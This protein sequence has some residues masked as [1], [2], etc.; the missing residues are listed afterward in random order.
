MYYVKM[1]KIK[2]CINTIYLAITLKS[3]LIYT[4]WIISRLQT[5]NTNEK[6]IV[7]N[8]RHVNIFRPT[9]R[10][11]IENYSEM[12]RALSAGFIEDR[13]VSSCSYNGRRGV[14]IAA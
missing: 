5:M 3:T 14:R 7:I 9:F 2:K 12:L 1:Y 6:E 8:R 10:R 4:W 11:T 13:N